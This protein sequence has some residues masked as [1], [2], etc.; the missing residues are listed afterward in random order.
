MFNFNTGNLITH[1]AVKKCESDSAYQKH[2]DS[3]KI[4]YFHNNPSNVIIVL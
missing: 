2:K 1:S 3:Y 4:R